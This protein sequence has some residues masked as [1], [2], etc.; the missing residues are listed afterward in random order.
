MGL[1]DVAGLVTNDPGT[2][3]KIVNVLNVLG[4]RQLTL[5][6]LLDATD[7]NERY[8]RFLITKLRSIRLIMG[9]K[10]NNKYFYYLSYESFTTYLKTKYS[11]A[12]Y[13]LVK[14]G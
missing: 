8:L 7:F 14:R 1:N 5:E 13:N 10:R 11:D 3:E 2:K 12:I 6:Q 9:E 4:K